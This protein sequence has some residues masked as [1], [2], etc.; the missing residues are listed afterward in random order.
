MNAASWV[1]GAARPGVDKITFVRQPFDALLAR[2]LPM[3][4]QF[5]DNYITNGAVQ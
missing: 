2:F 4:D 1:D 3:T 5:T